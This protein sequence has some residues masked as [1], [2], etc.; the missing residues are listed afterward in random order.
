[1]RQALKVF[2]IIMI[3]TGGLALIGSMDMGEDGI[4][5]I[6]GGLMFIAQGVLALIYIGQQDK[7]V[8]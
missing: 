2:S 3:A 8:K 5:A 7:L 1:V 4:S 6:V